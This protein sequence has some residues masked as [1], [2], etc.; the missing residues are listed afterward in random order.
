METTRPHLCQI[1]AYSV[2]FGFLVLLTMAT[3]VDGTEDLS[4]LPEITKVSIPPVT[5]I[6]TSGKN[7]IEG[8]STTHFLEQQPTS[9][10]PHP[11]ESVVPTILSPNKSISKDLSL[12]HKVS[13]E[14]PPITYGLA[15][16]EPGATI[17]TSDIYSSTSQKI[18]HATKATVVQKSHMTT[19][20]EETFSETTATLKTTFGRPSVFKPRANSGKTKGE[21]MPSMT[22]KQYVPDDTKTYD[23]ST[24][25]PRKWL[26]T[27]RPESGLGQWSLTT[28]T[29][30]ETTRSGSDPTASP[31]EKSRLGII[32]PIVIFALLLLIL[33]I[34]FL[35][36]RRRR[37]SGSTSFNAGW[38]EQVAVPDDSGL[39]GEVEQG[40]AAAGEGETKRNTL[41]TFSGKRQSRVPSVAMEEIGGKEEKEESQ[42][43]LHGDAGRASSPEA[44]GEANGKLP[45]L[46][47]Q[48]P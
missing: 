22:P 11:T 2:P 14:L 29:I 4:T 15:S 26:L 33:L 17:T 9:P 40:A 30:T 27:T 7:D 16:T 35:Y 47:M 23:I 32:V 44:S 45:E 31:S 43:L 3:H 28:V 38:A 46:T 20:K 6:L 18:I 13:S 5:T 24:R 37:R 25:G 19:G 36:C 10:L 48:S 34:A 8:L 12:V 42:K 41:T 21:I 39:D 1:I